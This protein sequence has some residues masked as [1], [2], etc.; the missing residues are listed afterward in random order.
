MIDFLRY[1]ESTINV[2]GPECDAIG[3]AA[4]Q[5]RL[6]IVVGVIERDGGTLYCTALMDSCWANTAN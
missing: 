5:H 2:P 1:Y 4:C 3:Q 6:H